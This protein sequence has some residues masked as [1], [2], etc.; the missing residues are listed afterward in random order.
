MV[1]V[2]SEPVGL[3]FSEMNI[4]PRLQ[5]D[6]FLSHPYG[7]VLVFLEL[8]VGGTEHGET[9]IARITKGLEKN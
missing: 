7:V 2:T 4:G 3:K 1:C 6:D 9:W 5:T 8:K